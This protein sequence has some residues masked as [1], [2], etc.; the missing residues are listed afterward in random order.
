MEC[1]NQ[2]TYIITIAIQTHGS[3]FEL[4]LSSEKSKLFDNVRLFSKAGDFD[5]SYSNRLGEFYVVNKLNELFQKNLQQPSINSIE[6][7][8]EYS[9]P[10]YSQ[11]L[12]DFDVN[13][14][15]KICRLFHNVTVDKIFSTALNINDNL[16]TC[17]IDYLMPEYQGI[18]LISVHQKIDDTYFKLIYPLNNNTNNKNLNLLNI[19]DLTKF[20]NIFGKS[21]VNIEKFVSDLPYEEYIKREKYIQNNKKFSQQEK[22]Q[23]LDQQKKEF[24]DVIQNWSGVEMNNSKSGTIIENIKMS[25]L[26]QIINEIVGNKCNINL[27]DYSCNS[28]SRYL[29][30]EQKSYGKFFETYDIENPPDR[31]WGGKKRNKTKKHLKKRNKRIKKR[32]RNLSRKI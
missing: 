6:E 11:F 29:P 3:I 28:F 30:K 31:T 13:N 24:Y 10:K 7:Y 26:V 15:E 23:M 18:F 25:V 32:R 5:Y 12:K 17:A 22:E 19:S 27:F 16:L 4:N 14:T 20:A 1:I 21:S 9:K 8:V 2:G